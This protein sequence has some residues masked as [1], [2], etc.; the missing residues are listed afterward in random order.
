V[1]GTAARLRNLDE[2]LRQAT[3]LISQRF[4]FYHVGIFLL[5]ERGD[6][7]V[8]RA[9]SSDGGQRM[10]ARGHRLKVGQ[11][12]I[13]GYVTATSQP[14]IAS[15]VDED[16][17]FFNNP[18]LPLTH[19]E[20]ALPLI[21]GRKVLGALDVQSTE[22]A[23]F[24]E[25]DITT[26]KVLADQLAI[27]IEN[28][29]LFTENQA[30]LDAARRAYGQMG[31]EGW[32]RMLRERQTTLGFI[33][34]T[35]EEVLPASAETSPESLQAIRSGEPVLA[36]NGTTLHLPIK[37]RGQGIGAIRLN[38]PAAKGAWGPEDITLAGTLA[39]QLGTALESARL[40]NDISVR[41]E[42]E[43]AI[44]EIVSKIS[45]SIQLDTIL[46]TTVQEL[47]QVL[48]ETEIILQLGA[49]APKGNHRE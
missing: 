24:S 2:L 25:E 13:V 4:G 19:S 40:Y 44:S 8:L 31:R 1:G 7:A 48:G 18:D 12:G 36:S 42:R 32:Q 34:L 5:D 17:E 14:R 21:I 6:Y 11:V 3:R 41:A 26:L 30:A 10:L 33:S 45:S 22:E 23:A 49:G 37:V 39:E 29:R 16:T 28:A 27:A 47:G 43:Y 15:D 9:A 46:R 35:E 20:M 38:K